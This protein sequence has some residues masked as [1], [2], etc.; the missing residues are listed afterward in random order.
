M[1]P[2]ADSFN[3][4]ISV[5]KSMFHTVCPRSSDPILY[6]NLL[7]KMITASWTDGLRKRLLDYSCTRLL[8]DLGF[9]M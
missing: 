5:K 3:P 9:T 8:I 7:Y 2:F 6:S 4:I 1:A